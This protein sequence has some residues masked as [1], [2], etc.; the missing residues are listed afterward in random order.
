MQRAFLIDPDS[1]QYIRL[2]ER[3]RDRIEQLI[4]DF[5]GGYAGSDRVEGATFMVASLHYLLGDANSASTA[6]DVAFWSGNSTAS[7]WNLRA[8]LETQ[9]VVDRT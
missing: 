4:E 9:S 3:L 7:I 2:D 5:E 8:L 1:I 6:I